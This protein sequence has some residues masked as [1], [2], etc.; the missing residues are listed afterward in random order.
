MA[1]ERAEDLPEQGEESMEHGD[2]TY[3]L[4]SGL[5]EGK[6][7]KAGDVVKFRVIGKDENGDVEV[8]YYHDEG[9]K[10]SGW[11]DDMRKSVGSA[12]GPETQMEGY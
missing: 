6:E 11:Q 1:I 8:E 2:D 10:G 9:S 12:S 5:L 3:F 7:V 4:P